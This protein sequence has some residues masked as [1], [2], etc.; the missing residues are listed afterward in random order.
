M[1]PSSNREEPALA[2]KFVKVEPFVENFHWPL[3]LSVK[4]MATPVMVPLSK[5]DAALAFK[6]VETASPVLVAGSSRIVVKA[7]FAVN[8]V[9]L[10]VR[11]D[12][13]PPNKTGASFTEITFRT[14]LPAPSSSP[15][16]SRKPLSVTTT[17][18]VADPLAPGVGVKVN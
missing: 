11:L 6:K 1:A 2:L 18:T 16:F 7:S 9:P 17:L 3:L 8:V 12:D 14:K 13:P 15:P 4:V 10:P 5:S